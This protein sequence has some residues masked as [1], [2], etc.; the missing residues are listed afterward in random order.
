M[1]VIKSGEAWVACLGASVGR[2]AGS[3]SAENFLVGWHNLV[4]TMEPGLMVYVCAPLFLLGC[5]NCVHLSFN[6]RVMLR[7][8]DIFNE[9][10]VFHVKGRGTCAGTNRSFDT[11]V[12]NYW[13]ID[14]SGRGRE[15]SEYPSVN[16]GVTRSEWIISINEIPSFVIFLVILRPAVILIFVAGTLFGRDV[17]YVLD[18][19]RVKWMFPSID[20]AR[21]NIRLVGVI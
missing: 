18:V 20:G 2:N 3:S 6:P 13:F 16:K 10:D 14:T 5:K 1:A 7:E 9:I 15:L 4:G 12:G 11:A 17:K 21:A 19:S 8:Q